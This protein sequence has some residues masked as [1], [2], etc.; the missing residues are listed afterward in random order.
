[1]NNDNLQLRSIEYRAS[2][3]N[4][5][6]FLLQ[7]NSTL[8]TI[9]KFECSLLKLFMLLFGHF[10]NSLTQIMFCSDKFIKSVILLK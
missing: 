5:F 3:G 8:K 1:M 7:E 9:M 6:C 4:P 10:S 2:K